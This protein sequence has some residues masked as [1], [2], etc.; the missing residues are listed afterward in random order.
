M[1]TAQRD[2]KTSQ[3][4]NQQHLQQ[5]TADACTA[6]DVDMLQWLERNTLFHLHT[7]LKVHSKGHI[8][9]LSPNGLNSTLIAQQ[10]C[11]VCKSVLCI[12]NVRS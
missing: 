4:Q 12:L 1:E 2:L 11:K 3:F 9:H 7:C 5:R 6:V 10:G 8:R